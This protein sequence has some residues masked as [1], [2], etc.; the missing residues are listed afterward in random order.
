VAETFGGG[1]R[2]VIYGAS[3]GGHAALFARSQAAEY[4]P[5][6]DVIGVVAAASVTDPATF[7]LPG[8]TDPD[9]FPFTAEAILAWSEVYEEPNLTDLVVVEDAENVRLAR[10]ELC[11]ESLVPPRPLDEVFLDEPQQVDLWQALLVEN[12]PPAGDLDIP[13]LLIHGDADEL[14]PVSGTVAYHDA[15]CEDGE[16]TSFLRVPEWTHSDGIVVSIP[17][18]VSWVT[19]VFDGASPPNDC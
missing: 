5:E 18:T 7:L 8:R 10:D 19:A 17:D 11:T 6:L 3:Q 2:S 12:T 4:A 15:L 14:V 9:I 16:V 13:V 1:N